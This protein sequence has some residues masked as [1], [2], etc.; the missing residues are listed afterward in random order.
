MVTSDTL[1]TG[2]TLVDAARSPPPPLAPITTG[3]APSSAAAAEAANLFLAAPAGTPRLL[4]VGAADSAD[5]GSKESLSATPRHAAGSG[6]KE[7]AV[8]LPV[9]LATAVAM[10]ASTLRAGGAV[11]VVASQLLISGSSVGASSG[12]GGRK[13]RSDSTGMPTSRSIVSC[14]CRRAKTW[15]IS[16]T[17]AAKRL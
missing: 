8:L 1:E 2:A 7:W 15:D 6:G 17:T 9:A 14:S 3:V 5:T 4:E 11:A 16:R 13:S 12:G 10:A